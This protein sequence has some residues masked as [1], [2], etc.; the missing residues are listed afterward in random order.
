MAQYTTGE[1]ARLCNVTVRTVQ[2]YDAKDLLK[3]TDLTEGGR[4][5]YTDEDLRHL[6]IICFLKD[7]RFSL[8]DISEL[9]G[10]S[11]MNSILTL[12]IENQSKAISQNIEEECARLD[13]IEGLRRNLGF[14]NNIDTESIGVMADIMENRKKLKAAR[15]RLFLAGLIM[16]LAWLPT[17]IY[18]IVSGVWWPFAL[19]ALVAIILGVAISTY[20]MGRVAYVCP[21]DHTVFRPPARKMFFARHTPSLRMLTCPTC[22]QKHYCLE[23]YAPSGQPE[24]TDGTLIWPKGGGAR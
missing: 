16:D 22:G 24:D 23:V 8:Q 21:E 14:F 12:L 2:F 11:D 10:A 19:G 3:P 13:R 7:L 5:L 17:L 6:Q 15:V 9:L 20:Y 1:L 4:R 18:G